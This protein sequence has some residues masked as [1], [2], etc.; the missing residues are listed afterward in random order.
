MNFIRDDF[1]FIDLD[2]I[3]F[4]RKTN[5]SKNVFFFEY[6]GELYFYKVIRELE[7]IY[8]ELIASE[9]ALKY[10]LDCL[11]YDIAIYDETIG[12]ISK[13]FIQQN[14]RYI[15]MEEILKR[16]YKIDNVAQKNN[17]EDIWY[18]IDLY[19]QDFNITKRLMDKIVNIFIF[20]ILIGNVDRHLFNFGIIECDNFVDIAPI[21]DN[22]KMLSESSIYYGDYSIGICESD[23][24]YC[25]RQLEPIDNYIYKFINISD[26]RYKHLLKE[27]L[28]IISQKNISEIIL[29]VENKINSKIPKPIKD[30]I[31][32]RF[33]INNKMINSILNSK[34]HIKTYK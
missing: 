15:P 33:Y 13:N 14:K 16:V 22:E 19:Y 17:L 26:I 21:F 12:V 31:I 4:S 23:Y 34:E 5:V 10:K 27:K 9:L 8:N 2:I 32:K 6:M 20:D 30:K 7:N 28:E 1:G 3:K 25:I 11:D 24:S 18:A 29:K